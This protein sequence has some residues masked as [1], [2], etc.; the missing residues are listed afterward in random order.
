MKP[1]DAEIH[2]AKLRQRIQSAICT[3][4]AT[5]EICL[6]LDF[7]SGGGNVDSVVGSLQ[8]HT[9][10][11]Q[12]LIQTRTYRGV[13][14]GKETKIEA[15]IGH[16]G[17]WIA[18]V[19]ITTSDSDPCQFVYDKEESDADHELIRFLSTAMKSIK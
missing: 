7:V 12:I 15:A 14:T 13:E 8:G 9:L 11:G 5:G 17:E 2:F 6:D 3:S 16:T 1:S 18:I 19:T 4:F 10:S